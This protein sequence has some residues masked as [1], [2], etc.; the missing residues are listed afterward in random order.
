MK[1]GAVVALLCAVLLAG[2][3]SSGSLASDVADQLPDL[4]EQGFTSFECGDGDAIGE[5]F[6]EPAE[7]DYVAQCWVGSPSGTY[8]D[9]VQLTHNKVLE[10][11]GG[12]DL[13]A[14][15]CPADSLTAAGG[16]ACRAAYIERGGESVLVRTVVIL[17]EPREVLAD[18]PESPTQEDI[19]TALVGAKVEI[20][21]GTEPTTQGGTP[22]PSATP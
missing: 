7:G 8:L 17:A 19:L 4:T 22:A 16:I 9:A 14:S 12:V 21:V 18:L 13:T 6:Q 3:S 1:A 11:T 20:L 10:E 5:S 2:C 15:V